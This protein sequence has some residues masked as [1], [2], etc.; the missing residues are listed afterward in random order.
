MHG[1]E[2]QRAEYVQRLDSAVGHVVE[3]LRALPEV[4]RISLFG[5]YARGRR[6]LLT[7]L[8]ILVVLD[9]TEPVWERL[10]R[11]YGLLDAGVD[12]DLLAWTPDE[13]TRMAQRPFGRVIAAEERVLYEA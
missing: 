5:S 8:D 12:I 2:R 10:A 1:L 6:D 7:D 4:R 3:R 11:L 13:H 9:T